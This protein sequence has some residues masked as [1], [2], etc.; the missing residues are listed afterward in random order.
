MKLK[1]KEEQ[2][3]WRM[4]RRYANAVANDSWKGGVDPEATPYIEAELKR[5][6]EVVLAEIDRLTS[7]DTTPRAV[8]EDY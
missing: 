3:L 5:S 7:I 8:R 4:V 6:K 2:R 1:T